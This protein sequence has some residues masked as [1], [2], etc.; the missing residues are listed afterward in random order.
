MGVIMYRARI[1]VYAHGSRALQAG[2]SHSRATA[3]GPRAPTARHSAGER[4]RR[5]APQER[6]EAT[7][8][9]NGEAR[10]QNAEIEAIT[11]PNRA[12]A[13][14]AC[15]VYVWSVAQSVDCARL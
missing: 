11:E 2:K 4:G 15:V 14:G 6:G 12:A 3:E 7:D 13:G 9:I 10:K 5:T 8:E 1:T